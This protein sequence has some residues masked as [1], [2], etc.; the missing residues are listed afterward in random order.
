MPTIVERLDKQRAERLARL[1]RERNM[2]RSE[3]ICALIDRGGRV[4]SG[5][6]LIEW[7]ERAAGGIGVGAKTFVKSLPHVL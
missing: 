3:V 5:E 2:T 6:D 4:A 1:A 7:V